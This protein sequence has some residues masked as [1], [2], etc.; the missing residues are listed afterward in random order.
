MFSHLFLCHV[1]LKS[2]IAISTSPISNVVWIIR[3]VIKTSNIACS[4]WWGRKVNKTSSLQLT[5][6]HF[7]WMFTWILRQESQFTPKYNFPCPTLSLPI[8]AWYPYK[9]DYCSQWSPTYEELR[10]TALCGLSAVQS[11][12]RWFNMP[13]HVYHVMGLWGIH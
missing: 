5:Q 8:I 4:Y 12:H 13:T 10:R 2:G 3:V 7:T 11:T 1:C 9:V 6:R